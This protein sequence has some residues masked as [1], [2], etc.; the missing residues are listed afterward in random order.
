M[1]AVEVL[2]DLLVLGL[3]VAEVLLPRVEVVLVLSTVVASIAGQ[4]ITRDLTVIRA[5]LTYYFWTILACSLWKVSCL[6]F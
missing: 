6:Y 1:V 4:R 5:R 3:D 2:A